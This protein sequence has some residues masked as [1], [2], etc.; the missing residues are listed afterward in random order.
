MNIKFRGGL[1][2]LKR[3]HGFLEVTT[4]QTLGGRGGES[5][6]EG[7]DDFGV[8]VFL[9]HT[10]LTDILG[11]LEKLEWWFEQ[12]IDKEKERFEGDEYGGEI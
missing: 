10:C 2:G 3:L 1:L 4:A 12:D 8:E 11:F 6:W 9:F 5:F 7:G